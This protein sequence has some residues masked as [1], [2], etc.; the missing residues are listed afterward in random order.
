[1]NLNLAGQQA[2]YDEIRP[3][4]VKFRNAMN[5]RLPMWNKFNTKKKKRWILSDKDPIMGLSDQLIEYFVNNFPDLVVY[6]IDK[7][8]QDNP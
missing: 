2:L 8:V 5:E 3:K 7:Y 6:Y 4:F 1:M